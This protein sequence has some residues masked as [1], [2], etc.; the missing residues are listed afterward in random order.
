VTQQTRASILV[1]EDDAGVCQLL[2][3]ILGSHYDVHI[4][5]DGF[6]ALEYV[7]QHTPH[8]VILDVGMPRV[9]GLEV[10][11]RLRSINRFLNTAIIILTAD[12]D[13]RTRDGARLYGADLFVAKPLQARRLLGQ[14]RDLLASY[15][16]R[17]PTKPVIGDNLPR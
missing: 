15:S 16:R 4:V 9:D 3:V 17:E 8:L 14:V 10:C 7:K 6:E 5:N 13:P 2:E 1:A 11:S 12:A